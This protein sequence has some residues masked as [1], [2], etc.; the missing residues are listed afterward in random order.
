MSIRPTGPG[1]FTP[2]IIIL[3]YCN[4]TAQA[5]PQSGSPKEQQRQVFEQY[6]Q[7]VLKRFLNRTFSLVQT[8]SSPVWLTQQMQQRY[9]T[10][11]HLESLQTD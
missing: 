10:E 8:F 9:L 2:Y 4:K 7:D 11:F 1:W 3:T 6:I 5:L